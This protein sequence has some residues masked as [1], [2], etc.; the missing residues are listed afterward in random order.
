MDQILCKL[1]GNLKDLKEFPQANGKVRKRTC[2][3]CR[4]K[5]DRAKLKL[6]MIEALGS[7]CN[8]CS[9]ANP[10]FLSLDHVKNNGH[11]Y[12]EKYNEQQIYRLARREGW[13]KDRY[14][15]LCM[16]CNF[17]KGHFKECPHKLG[18]TAEMALEQLKHEARTI[19]RTRHDYQA[20]YTSNQHEKVQ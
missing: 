7:K 9:E 8:C 6:D 1:C 10:Y 3:N 19:M 14:A 5:R 18:I 16:N 20:S 17:A 12:R 15:L 11:E 4:G 2:W 13:P